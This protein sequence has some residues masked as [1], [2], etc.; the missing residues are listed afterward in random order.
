MLYETA[1]I[2]LRGARRA[3]PIK[4]EAMPPLWNERYLAVWR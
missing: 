2:G 3:R 1:T 4:E